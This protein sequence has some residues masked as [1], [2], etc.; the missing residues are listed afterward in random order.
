MIV[1]PFKFQSGK[2]VAQTR[3]GAL[4]LMSRKLDCRPPLVQREYMKHYRGILSVLRTKLK[5]R[6][7]HLGEGKEGF[8]PPF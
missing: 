3:E 6:S 8:A 4:S 2:F 1:Q 5:S 7:V